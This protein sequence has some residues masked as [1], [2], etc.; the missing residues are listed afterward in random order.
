MSSPSKVEFI[1]QANRQG[2]RTYLYFVATA[3]PDINVS[4]VA[5]RVS[6]GG[7]PVP[8]QA[9]RSRYDRS[10]ALLLPALSAATR[11]YVFDNSADG[12]R[13]TLIAEKLESGEIELRAD[14]VPRWGQVANVVGW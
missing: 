1:E 14:R 10:L 5:N 6:K 3:D 11:A 9:I 13:H 7:H 4:R 12:A 2:Y 8:E